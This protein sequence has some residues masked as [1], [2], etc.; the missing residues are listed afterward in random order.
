MPKRSSHSSHASPSEIEAV[1]A[2]EH[3][4]LSLVGQRRAG[5]EVDQHLRG[6]RV[7]AGERDALPGRDRQ[8]VDAQRPQPAV[9]LP[10]VRDRENRRRPTS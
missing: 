8:V 6:A 9:G 5:H 10:D 3:E 7:E 1:L 2:T 4:H